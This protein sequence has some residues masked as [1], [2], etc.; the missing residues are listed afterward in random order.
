MLAQTKHRLLAA[1]LA[2]ALAASAALAQAPAPQQQDEGGEMQPRL[3]WGVIIVKY[4]AGEV[5]STF[6]KWVSNKIVPGN[7]TAKAESGVPPVAFASLAVEHLRGRQDTT[8]G[9]YIAR[10]IGDTGSRDAPPVAFERPAAPMRFD[11][12]APNYQGVHVAIVGADRSG[13]ITELR[14]IRG[15]FRTGERFKLRVVSTFGGRLV[16]DNI[17][18]RGERRQIYPPESGAVVVLQAGAD[19][20][21]PLGRDEFFEFARATGDEQ[22]V[23]ALRDPRAVG[24]AASRTRVYRQDEEFGTHFVQEVARDTYPVISES[25]RLEHR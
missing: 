11:Q 9:A 13:T 12:G 8:G 1:A 15:G 16:I 23:I 19:T 21:L 24:A 2:G 18:P 10:G 5:F 3:I 7:E 14:P 4:L 6:S 17:N 22:L 25:I 20:L